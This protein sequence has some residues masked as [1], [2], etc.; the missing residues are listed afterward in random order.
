MT[1]RMTLLLG[2]AFYRT[3]GNEAST[4]VTP[5]ACSVRCRLTGLGER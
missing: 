1:L 5:F 2:V 4:R 3:R